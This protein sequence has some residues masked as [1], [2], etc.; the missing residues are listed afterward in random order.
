[1]LFF[2]QQVT[3]TRQ[4]F[5]WLC[6][7]KVNAVISCCRHHKEGL[8]SWSDSQRSVLTENRLPKIG[9]EVWRIV[10]QDIIER[11]AACRGTEL[12]SGCEANAED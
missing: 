10:S 9:C 4:T 11:I 5:T 12:Q 2:L 8:T 3:S 1:M 7:A 6:R